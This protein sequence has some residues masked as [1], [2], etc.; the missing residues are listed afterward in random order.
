MKNGYFVAPPE[1]VRVGDMC[2][3]RR[4]DMDLAHTF[5][6]FVLGVDDEQYNNLHRS[7]VFELVGSP[8]GQRHIL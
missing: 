1:L 7:Q 3:L 5:S 2:R 8:L 4:N 6:V